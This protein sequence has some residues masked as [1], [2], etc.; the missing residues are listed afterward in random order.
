DLITELESHETDPD[1]L[2]DLFRLD[3]LATRMRR[4]AE[5]LLVLAG[6]GT[7][8]PRGAAD[9][10]HSPPA[11]SP[12]AETVEIQGLRHVASPGRPDGYTLAI[13]DFGRGMLTDE[14]ATAN[15]RL[16][17]ARAVPEAA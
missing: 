17:G 7:P 8:P 2:A 15:R 9:V 6:V 14:M 12:P 16:A 4:N 10:T 11:F 3:H 5:A 13:V 1:A